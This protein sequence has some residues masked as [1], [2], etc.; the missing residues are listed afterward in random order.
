MYICVCN[1]T[2]GTGGHNIHVRVYTYMYI[3]MYIESE[4]EPNIL[5]VKPE[6]TR[7]SCIT[8]HTTCLYNCTYTNVYI[9]TVPPPHK[10]LY[11]VFG[12]YIPLEANTSALESSTLTH[13]ENRCLFLWQISVYN[14]KHVCTA[15]RQLSFQHTITNVL[16]L[17]SQWYYTCTCMY[18]VYKSHN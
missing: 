12:V 10:V 8:L 15:Q 7:L 5:L 9:Y 1:S 4:M 16:Y 11:K 17:V 13:W 18:I 14:S 2:C 3:N 6:T